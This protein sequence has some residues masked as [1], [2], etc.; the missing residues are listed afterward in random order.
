MKKMSNF[1]KSDISGMAGVIY[2]KSST[3]SLLICRY[4]HSKFG[5]VWA[6]DNGAMKVGKIFH[7]VRYYKDHEGLG[8]LAQNY[9]PKT[10]LIFTFWHFGSIG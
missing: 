9:H 8:I 6:R 1:L 5:F 4:L 7:I 2:F 3:C 10:S